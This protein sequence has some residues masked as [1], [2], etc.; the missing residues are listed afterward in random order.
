VWRPWNKRKGTT[1]GYKGAHLP[2]ISID[3]PNPTVRDMR[4]SYNGVD[5]TAG[6]RRVTVRADVEEANV[7]ILEVIPGRLN[8]NV[9]A[10]MEIAITPDKERP[11]SVVDTGE[12]R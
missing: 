4:I 6:C 10:L 8:L 11:G 12:A 5:I 2:T 3:A 1:S 9:P 7:V